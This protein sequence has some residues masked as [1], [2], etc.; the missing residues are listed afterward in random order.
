MSTQKLCIGTESFNA[1]GWVG[2]VACS[3][4]GRIAALTTRDWDGTCLLTLWSPEGRLLQRHELGQPGYLVLFAPDG[5][6][7]AVSGDEGFVL[8]DVDTGA[9]ERSFDTGDVVHAVTFASSGAWIASAQDCEVRLWAADSGKL[10]QKFEHHSKYVWCLDFSPD[11]ALLASG[12]WDGWIYLVDTHS[13]EL[14]QKRRCNNVRAL[15]FAPDGERLCTGSGN[16]DVT[17]WHVPKLR[18]DRILATHSFGPDD[19]GAGVQWVA[20]S[21]DGK[22]VFSAGNEL[23]LRA[24]EPEGDLRFEVGAGSY[25]K[26]G[27]ADGAVSPDGQRIYYGNTDTVLSVIDASTGQIQTEPMPPSMCGCME[28][29]DGE[30]L[31]SGSRCTQLWSLETGALRQ[32]W[33]SS[34]SSRFAADK[35]LIHDA[36]DLLLVDPA[37]G[38]EHRKRSIVGLMSQDGAVSPDGGRYAE[39]S[40]EEI[41]I[42]SLPQLEQQAVFSHTSEVLSC[43]FGPTGTRLA[44]VTYEN[45]TVWDLLSQTALCTHAHGMEGPTAAFAPDGSHLALTGIVNHQRIVVALDIAA[46]QVD[47]NIPAPHPVLHRS[48]TCGLCYL[49]ST[50]I[51]VANPDARV[52]VLDLASSAWDTE[53]DPELPYS[54]SHHCDA[55]PLAISPDG[56]Q[57]ASVGTDGTIRIWPVQ[58]TPRVS[59]SERSEAPTPTS[60][61][62]PAAPK[63]ADEAGQRLEGVTLCFDGKLQKIQKRCAQA[64]VE[65]LGGSVAK[66]P[67]RAL[68][69]LVTAASTSGSPSAKASATFKKVQARIDK[70]EAIIVWTE[71]EFLR[72]VAPSRN[73]AQS[74]L[75]GG[76]EGVAQWNF[77]RL[78][79]GE[80]P[81]RG[82]FLPT[83][84]LRGLDLAE[85]NLGDADLE[86]LSLAR[87]CLRNCDLRE[88]RLSS[89][90]FREA[91]LRGALLDGVS[92]YHCDLTQ[93]DLRGASLKGAQ[94]WMVKLGRAKLEGADLTD[95][96]LAWAELGEADLRQLDLTTVKMKENTWDN[97]TRWPDGFDPPPSGSGQ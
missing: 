30:L 40:S 24:D 44:V 56:V 83:P 14:V 89:S 79:N 61:P 94:L 23:L 41:R 28:I 51:A 19:I 22:T 76:T 54:G 68:T 6:H 4:D 9:V 20:F 65:T 1:Y 13:H 85:A 45:A 96:Q 95:A 55:W 42:W 5:Q 88:V 52:H 33:P 10:A 75:T 50:R 66:S 67:T 7:V 3:G 74:L 63:D 73:Q 48:P 16:G 38:S 17:L 34:G 2:S 46:N 12:G 71:G 59:V 36:G 86:D 78:G 80:E 29:R 18:K 70:G 31:L 53:L 93:A 84:D 77:W 91:D 37:D 72:R 81:P 58:G 43:T 62:S 8:L 32:Q 69:H 25:Q 97:T 57:L 87:A 15:A 27:F 64:R 47:Q 39:I 90:D 49:T 35:I 26:V 60:T 82:G 21:P 92:L 11:S